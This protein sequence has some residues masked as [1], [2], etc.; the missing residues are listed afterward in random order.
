[1]SILPIP[2]TAQALIAQA[3]DLFA[4]A[5]S[6]LTGPSRV[7]VVNEAR[8]AVAYALRQHCPALSYDQIGQ[9]LGGRNHTTIMHAVAVPEQRAITDRNYALNLSALITEERGGG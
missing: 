6:D 3:A 2:T 4:C 5:P 7:R 8:Q 9:I 1:M